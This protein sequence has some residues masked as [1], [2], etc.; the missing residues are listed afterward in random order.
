MHIDIVESLEDLSRLRGDWDR[1][2]A[3]DPEAHYFLSWNW[4][5]RWFDR[6]VR[7]LVLAA[8]ESPQDT[9]Y[10]GFFPIQLRTQFAPGQGFLNSVMMGGSYFAAYTGIL[11]EPGCQD[12]VMPAFAD[13]IRSFNWTSLHLDDVYMS[14]ER[15]ELFLGRFPSDGFVREKVA[16]PVHVSGI[17]ENID[18]DVYVYVKLPDDFESFLA[19]QVGSKTRH[20]LRKALRALE[21]PDGLRVTHATAETIERDLEIFHRLWGTQWM[22]RQERYARSILDSCRH[23]LLSCFRDGT[24]FVPVLWNGDVPVGIQIILMD[25]PRNSLICFLGS[26]DLEFRRPQPGLLLHAYIMRWGIENGYRT[27][28][29]GTGD[30]SYKFSFGSD[31]HRVERLRVSTRTGRNL[32]ERLD[33]R[34]ISAVLH[35]AMRMQEGGGL[36]DAELGCRQILA[37]EPAHAGALALLQKIKAADLAAAA[38]ESETALFETASA[39]HRTGRLAEAEAGYRRLLAVSPVHFEATHQ[40]GIVLLQRGQGKA[41][42]LELRRALEIRPDSA[43][44]HCNYGNVL[45]QMGEF[46]KALASYDRAIAVEPGHAIAFNNRGNVLRNLGRLEEALA[47]YEQA[48]ALQPGYARA[49]RGRDAVLMAMDVNPAQPAET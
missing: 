17:G 30:F 4:I 27:Y 6:P 24:L 32:G 18:H 44:V 31:S 22:P 48:L 21:E 41:A 8:R 45:A 2:Y 19:N 15:L 26:R 12:R 29:L 36:T 23:M 34:T 14:P 39:H 10:V 16:R 43:P 42:E 9:A 3:A 13:A 7:W 20:H 46:E 35:N 25:R 49:L 40:L 1:V 38:G 33:P 5:A 11:C 28:D 47:S 37:V